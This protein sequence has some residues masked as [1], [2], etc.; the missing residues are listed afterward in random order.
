MY[1]GLGCSR[2]VFN[3]FSVVVGHAEEQLSLGCVAR[4]GAVDDRLDLEEVWSCAIAVDDVPEVRQA[5][6]AELALLAFQTDAGLSK[7]S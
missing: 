5:F 7:S 6:H 3:K 1:N 4:R 2:H